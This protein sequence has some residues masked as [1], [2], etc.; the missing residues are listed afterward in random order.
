MRKVRIILRKGAKPWSIVLYDAA[1]SALFLSS[2]AIQANDD[3]RK[4]IKLEQE[5]VLEVEWLGSEWVFRDEVKDDSLTQGKPHIKYDKVKIGKMTPI[6][7]SAQRSGYLRIYTGWVT[8]DTIPW[9]DGD[10]RRG[11]KITHV[12]GKIQSKF[13]LSKL[14]VQDMTPISEKE[15]V[16]DLQ[17][18]S[19]SSKKK[20]VIN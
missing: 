20:K 17:S 8:G 9:P 12:K 18:S 10:K 3:Y 1:E 14:F 2:E 4:V 6:V 11:L 19:T 16:E 7:G 5:D 13:D 15:D